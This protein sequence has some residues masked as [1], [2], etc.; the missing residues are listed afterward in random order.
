L[1]GVSCTYQLYSLYC[2]LS[3]SLPTAALCAAML[4]YSF[5]TLPLSSSPVI[6][7]VPHIPFPFPFPSPFPFPYHYRS[8]TLPFL[9]PFPPSLPIFPSTSLSLPAPNPFPPS[10]HL[11][12]IFCLLSLLS[13]LCKQHAAHHVFVA[14]RTDCCVEGD[15]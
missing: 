9:F 3:A 10:S 1:T 11:H 5:I 14:T 15:S 4:M 8:L 2:I 13:V 7:H 6:G 12:L